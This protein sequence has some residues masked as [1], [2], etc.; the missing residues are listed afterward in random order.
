MDSF[1]FCSQAI[2]FFKGKHCHFWTRKVLF[3]DFFKTT[4]AKSSGKLRR[5]TPSFGCTLEVRLKKYFFR[6]KTFLFFTIQ[7]WNFQ[8]LFEIEFREISQNINSFRLFRQLLF[9]FFLWVVRFHEFLFQTD[10]ESFSFLP[11]KTKQ[12]IIPKIFLKKPG[13]DKYP[14]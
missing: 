1:F 9:S 14:D 12:K 6:N 11:W 4:W 5:L 3:D 2:N 10:F 7:R 8:Y 13:L